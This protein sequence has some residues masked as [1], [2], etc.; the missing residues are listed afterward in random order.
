MTRWPDDA[1]VRVEH[2][3]DQLGGIRRMAA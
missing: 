2:G 1:A 3:D